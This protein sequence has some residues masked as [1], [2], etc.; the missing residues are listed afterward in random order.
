LLETKHQQPATE[1]QIEHSV[2]N[3]ADLKLATY[4]DAAEACKSFG[5]EICDAPYAAWRAMVV[6]EDSKYVYYFLLF[7]Y[8]FHFPYYHSISFYFKY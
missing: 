6:A 3:L 7:N 4:N 8:V 1:F 5:N 2:Y